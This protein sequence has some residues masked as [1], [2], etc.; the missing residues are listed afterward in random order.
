MGFTLFWKDLWIGELLLEVRF[1]RLFE[2]ADNKLVTIA[3]MHCFGWGVNGE[4]W[5]WRK[6][7]FALEEELVRE[8]CNFII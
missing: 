5:K 4:A 2:L 1:R 8:A 6:R 3:K 7:L